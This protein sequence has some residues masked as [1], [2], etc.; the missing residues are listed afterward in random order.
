MFH[1]LNADIIQLTEF[2]QLAKVASITLP[3][4]KL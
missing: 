4:F 2:E 3:I 1:P